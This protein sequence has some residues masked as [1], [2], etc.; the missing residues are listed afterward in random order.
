MNP[1]QKIV[2]H[3][4]SWTTIVAGAAITLMML[5]ISFDVLLRYASGRGMPGTLSIVSYYYMVIAAFVPLAFAELRN[6]HIQMELITDLL[7]SRE[8]RILQ[9][10]VLVP[11]ALVTGVL[12]WRGFEIALSQTRI[13]AAQIQ[14]SSSIP[15]WPAYY[16]LP[17]GAG[18]MTILVVLRFLSFL[19]GRQ[20]LL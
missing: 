7:P 20:N 1:I 5:H 6:A 15:V 2:E 8:G 3:V 14:G 9:G 19:K 4:I 12:T 11:T 18:L 16:A 17:L 13:G 10:W